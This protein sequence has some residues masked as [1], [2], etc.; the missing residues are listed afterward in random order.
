M[1]YVFGILVTMVA[2]S[3]L[4]IHPPPVSLV[5]TVALV[6]LVGLFLAV[7]DLILYYPELFYLDVS[8]GGL[9]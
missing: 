3:I 8:Y 5:I 6:F 2:F 4:A 1:V 7:R 9:L